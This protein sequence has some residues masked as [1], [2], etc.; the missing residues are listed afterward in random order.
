M[1]YCYLR[2]Y[3]FA[4][5]RLLVGLLALRKYYGM[6]FHETRMEDGRWLKIDPNN[7][8]G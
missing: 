1:Y 8:W 6:E 2:R 3:V 5:V 7:F 4:S